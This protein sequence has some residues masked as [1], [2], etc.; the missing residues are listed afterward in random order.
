[1]ELTL[2]VDKGDKVQL[3]GYNKKTS[4]ATKDSTKCVKVNGKGFILAK[5]ATEGSAISYTSTDGKT[6]TINT[7]VKEPEF[8]ALT[9]SGGSAPQVKKSNVTIGKGDS[10]DVVIKNAPLTAAVDTGKTKLKGIELDSADFTVNTDGD[11]HL[12]GKSTGKGSAKIPFTVCG[13]KYTLKIKA[14]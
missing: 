12:T 14:K 2:T 5:K 11:L 4:N 7:V 10:F 13:K 3:P 1:M 8:T 9:V 6:I